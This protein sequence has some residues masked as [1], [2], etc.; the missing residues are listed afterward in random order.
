M[1]FIKNGKNWLIKD[2]N[3]LIISNEQKERY[4]KNILNPNHKPCECG[5]KKKSTS[6]TVEVPNDSIKETSTIK[7]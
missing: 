5:K 4:E 6:K 7:E 2:S 3:G 1:E